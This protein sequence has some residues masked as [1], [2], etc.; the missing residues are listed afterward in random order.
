MTPTNLFARRRHRSL[1][2]FAARALRPFARVLL[3]LIASDAFVVETPQLLITL[4]YAP[5]R[6]DDLLLAAAQRFIALFGGEMGDISSGAAGDV[7]YVSELVFRGL[8]QSDEP[9]T[10]SALL[11]VVDEL[12]RHN[13]YWVDEALEQSV[14]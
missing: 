4:Q 11:D 5:D 2:L 12:L 13:A 3:A 8:S 10:R 1:W 6:V 9:A 14:R 7:H